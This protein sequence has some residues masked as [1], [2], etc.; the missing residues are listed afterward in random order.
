MPAEPCLAFCV[1]AWKAGLAPESSVPVAEKV[2]TFSK[3]GIA[4]ASWAEVGAAFSA[5]PAML[6]RVPTTRP[7]DQR[8]R[9]L[10]FMAVS[11][12]AV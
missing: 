6:N 4:S 11:V 10:A 12:G 9:V 1:R 3:A 5:A 2:M 8:R 7:A